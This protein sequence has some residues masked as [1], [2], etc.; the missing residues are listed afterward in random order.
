MKT[1]SLCTGYGGLDKAAQ[2]VFGGDLAWWSDIEPGPI[3]VMEHHHP[4]EP[5]LGDIKAIDWATAPAVDLLT[6]G[7]P[8]Q[9]FSNAGKRLGTEDPRHL[10]PWIAEGIGVLRPRIVILE[11]VAAH[12]RRGFDVVSADLAALGYD[13]AWTVVRASDVGAPHQR[14]R[15]FVVAADPTRELHYRT[16]HVGPSGGAEHPDGHSS[17]ADA[18]GEREHEPPGVVTNIAGWSA[19]RDLRPDRWGVYA[20]AVARWERITGRMAPEPKV[21]GARGAK[22]LSPYLLE[23]M[24]GLPTGYVTGVPGLTRGQ[25]GKLLGNGVVPQQAEYAI[26][27]LIGAL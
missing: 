11:N 9:P 7:Y 20:P 5:N 27:G 12:L 15:I 26:R 21:T 2:A 13:T 24:M 1:G 18:N 25:M 3:A 8:C 10:W 19:D 17:L 23:W 14:A 6:A 22:V 4:G 16:G